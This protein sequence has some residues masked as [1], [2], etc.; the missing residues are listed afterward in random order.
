MVRLSWFLLTG[1]WRERHCCIWANR[2]KQ[3]RIHRQRSRQREGARRRGRGAAHQVEESGQRALVSASSDRRLCALGTWRRGLEQNV[4]V[5][6][7]EA[8]CSVLVQ[9]STT[10]SVQFSLHSALYL[11]TRYEGDFIPQVLLLQ[12][13]VNS[14]KIEIKLQRAKFPQ[15]PETLKSTE[16]VSGLSKIQTLRATEVIDTVLCT[17]TLCQNI[18]NHIISIMTDLRSDSN[19]VLHSCLLSQ[20]QS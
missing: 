3:V 8:C 19:I 6:S 13:N 9:P 15:I 4:C 12:Q 11:C 14:V 10:N 2:Q 18:N 17:C 7:A 5:S 20:S 1:L 16:C